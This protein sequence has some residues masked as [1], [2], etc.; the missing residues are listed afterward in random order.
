MVVLLAAVLLLVGAL[1]IWF[2]G[3][4]PQQM[5]LSED[6]PLAKAALPDRPL[7]IIAF[8]T[9]L[10]AR[11]FWPERLATALAACLDHPVTVERI[12]K[13][14]AGSDWAL[15]QVGRVLEAKPDIV[16]IEFAINDADLF[17]GL[18]RDS[19]YARHLELIGRLAG[20]PAAPALLLMTTNPV[21]WGW[22]SLQRPRLADYYLSY[23]ALAAETGSGLADLWPRWGAVGGD[24]SHPD[25][26][27]EAAI[28]LP[29]LGRLIGDRYGKDCGT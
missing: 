20:G 11:S 23:R 12:A 14:G 29:V 16:V 22:R 4:S 8:G 13:P 17:D 2:L 9:S 21:A 15:G 28:A 19:S 18:S 5:P 3:R 24:G 26:E 1:G 6:R 27:A 25:P 7:R 10:T